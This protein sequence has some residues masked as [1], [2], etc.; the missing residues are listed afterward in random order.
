MLPRIRRSKAF[1]T[2][3]S[4]SQKE[5]NCWTLYVTGDFHA[6]FASEL[7][8]MSE[9]KNSMLAES[10][11]FYEGETRKL[12]PFKHENYSFLKDEFVEVCLEAQKQLNNLHKS[13]VIFYGYAFIK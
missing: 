10:C 5:K 3:G 1:A 8:F 12:M 13:V 6:K 9:R 4:V 7:G 2:N 11:S